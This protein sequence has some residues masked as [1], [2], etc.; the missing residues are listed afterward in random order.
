MK[1]RAST[2]IVYLMFLVANTAYFFAF[3]AVDP[4]RTS[5]EFDR[6]AD[7][8][9]YGIFQLPAV[10]DYLKT[11]HLFVAI[12]EGR[13]CAG[14]GNFGPENGADVLSQN[15][16]ITLFYVQL[17]KILPL[18]YDLLAFIVN[19]LCLVL[20]YY[21]GVKI[22]SGLGWSTR[23][24]YLFFVN[25]QLILYSQLINKE[26]A[27]LLFVLL[28]TY[29]V[30]KRQRGKFAVATLA[31]WILRH[32]LFF[33][34]VFLYLIYFARRFRV[35]LWQM[36]AVSAFGAA[37]LAMRIMASNPEA[38]SE[39]GFS[40]FLLVANAEY[41]L[42][43]LLL[44]PIKVVQWIYEEMVL[45]LYFFADGR[46]NLYLMKELGVIVVVAVLAKRLIPI[47][48]RVKRGGMGG[49]RLL[50]SAIFAF[51]LMELIN[52]IIHQRYLFPVLVLLI[53]LGLCAPRRTTMA[54]GMGRV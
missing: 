46:I 2:L 33:F 29:L 4:I 37:W 28:L 20:A 39:S 50:L 27:T 16:G 13:F 15:F 49:E 5:A 34:A 22:I 53:M 36:Y 52:P 12:E 8:P 41:Y 9:Y 26:P 51:A 45:S 18:D 25:P 31:A 24:S 3:I 21:Y 7:V 35:R 14:C 32:Q 44:A 54:H 11:E 10:Y 17:S 40:R 6:R 30:S 23:Y 42:G 19:N 43:N 48:L 47:L 38:M 1:L